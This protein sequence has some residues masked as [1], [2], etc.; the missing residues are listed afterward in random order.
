PERDPSSSVWTRRMTAVRG[1]PRHMSGIDPAN[2][3]PPLGLV[4]FK[5][6]WRQPF[7]Y[8]DAEVVALMVEAHRW[9]P[10]PFRSATFATMIGLLAATGMRV[11]EVIGLGHTDVDW[12]QGVITV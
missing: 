8:S 9:S 1:F 5:Q 12:D 10:S 11:G 4:A 2:Q 3:I 7:V 6:R